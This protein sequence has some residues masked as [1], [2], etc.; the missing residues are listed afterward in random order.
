MKFHYS[1]GTLPS[2][3][4]PPPNHII[5]LTMQV[6][7]LSCFFLSF[8]SIYSPQYPVLKNVCFLIRRKT[9]LKNKIRKE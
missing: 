2:S 7:P 1:E 8:G 9:S 3:Q 5:N 6:S 4:Q